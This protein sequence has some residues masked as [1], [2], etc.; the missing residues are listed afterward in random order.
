VLV[1]HI[2]AKQLAKEIFG[3]E[4]NLIRVDMS[5]YQEKHTISRLIGSPPGYVGHDDGGQLNRTS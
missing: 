4:D 3:S 5:E 1:K 2:L